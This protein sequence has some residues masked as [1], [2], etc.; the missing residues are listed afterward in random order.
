MNV[1]IRNRFIIFAII[2]AVMFG[3]LF[4]QL[5]RL[6]IVHGEEYA[7]EANALDTRTITIPGA[8]GSIL[9]ASGLPLAYDQK[10][11]N[12]QFYRDP[13]KNTA[14]DRAYY[15][16]VIID[17]IAIVEENQGKTVDSF[18]IKYRET[19]GEYYFDFG[20]TNKQAAARREEKWRE[21][22]YIK[23]P[24]SGVPLTPEEIYLT[25]RERYQ[26]PAEMDFTEASKI[27]SIWQDVQLNSWVAYESITVAY[28]VSIQTVAEIRTHAAE[29]EGMSI[30]ESTVRVYPRGSVAA[31]VIGYES[32]ITEDILSQYTTESDSELAAR[33]ATRMQDDIAGRFD[34]SDDA[35]V[36]GRSLED[37]GFTAS[38]LT[39]VES[40]LDL[41]YS[42]DDLVGVEGIEKSM[43]AYLTGNTSQRQGKQEVEVDNM[44]IVQNI[45]SS[46]EPTQGD[47]VMLTLDIGMQMVAEQALEDEI[48]QIRAQQEAAFLAN[49]DNDHNGKPDYDG[50]VMDDLDFACSGA[51]I[52][53]DVN[54]GNVLALANNPS[55][56]LNLFTGG[57]SDS[58]YKDLLQ[59]EGFPLFNKAIQSLAMPGSVFKMVTATAA[60][61][62]G[63]TDLTEQIDCDYRFTT[64]I[65]NVNQAPHCWTKNSWK[66]QDQTVVEGLQHSCNFYFYTLAYRVGIDKLDKWGDIYG[67]T[68]STGIELPGEAVGIIGNQQLLYDASKPIDKQ[69]NSLPMLVYKTG[70]YSMVNLLKKFASEREV[71]YS[72]EVIDE[73]AKALVELMGIEWTQNENKVWVDP[74]GYAMGEHVRSILSD[75]M[76]IRTTVSQ[77]KGWDQQITS[78]LVQLKWTTYMTVTTG[79][80]Q[81]ITEVT[82]IAM[83]RYIA[84]I[85]NGGTVYE[86]HI[87]DKVLDQ[88]GNVVFDQQP[89]VYD[90][91]GA[92]EDYI[93]AIQE[94][95]SKV[96]SEE[97]GTA[98]KYFR[99]FPQVYR[100]QIAG[101]TGTAQVSTVDLENN[102]WF[103]CF[104]PYSKDDPTVKPEIAIVVYIPNG[105]IGGLS[106]YVAQDIL[107]YY[108]EQKKVVAEQEIPSSDALLY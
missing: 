39:G 8:R 102:S 38:Q 46:T 75:M 28:N 101:K 14:A 87:V 59:Q 69:A 68:V 51:A 50:L 19:T 85:A 12:V 78:V 24:S 15:T 70:R 37:F 64:G 32:R 107:L 45:L 91:V 21:N 96:V 27:L 62:E 72:D 83:A 54:T 104:A 42:V 84:A 4:V 61:M 74:E 35:T 9:D 82:P 55:Y 100:D 25:L 5:F 58:V 34:V 13:S 103:V 53:L 40:L 108:F 56:D 7:E 10:S 29:L 77:A 97:E 99:D 26:I 76:D 48:P 86:T 6:T 30:A 80:G 88:E 23:V 1:N 52:V 33:V 92:D 18:A 66:H 67:L 89:V 98:D 22:M 93:R 106:S 79:I 47:N 44:A 31:H 81:G 90:E 63:E 71:E 17:T 73:T 41:G 95:M 3:L 11:Y 20:L 49:E 57:I 16:G 94:G 43:E 65:V 2:A 36:G 60:L 105:Y